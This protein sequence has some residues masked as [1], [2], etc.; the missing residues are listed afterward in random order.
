MT[1]IVS[2][3]DSHVKQREKLIPDGDAINNE[4]LEELN[5]LFDLMSKIKH[6]TK[7]SVLAK[8][9]ELFHWDLSAAKP[10]LPANV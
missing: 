1:E 6:G 2:M 9:N 5:D 10:W 7:I 8:H 4:T 3:S